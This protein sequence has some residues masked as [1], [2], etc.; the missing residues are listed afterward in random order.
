M[1]LER[2]VAQCRQAAD[3]RLWAHAMNVGFKPV[4]SPGVEALTRDRLHHVDQ[5][6]LRFDTLA[7][8]NT[9]LVEAQADMG[10]GEHRRQKSRLAGS[11]SPAAAVAHAPAV[12]AR[13]CW[14]P[15]LVESCL[16]SAEPVFQPTLTSACSGRG[17]FQRGRAEGTVG[18]A[19][20]SCGFV[21]VVR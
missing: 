13:G 8:A 18:L 21:D 17:W 11:R 20:N 14:L 16:P 6:Y 12:P 2:L 3:R 10:V 19:S 5:H 4:A 7:A 15:T 1:T 9:V